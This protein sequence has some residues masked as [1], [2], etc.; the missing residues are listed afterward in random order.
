MHLLLV[1]LPRKTYHSFEVLSL[2][3]LAH[4][5]VLL[6]LFDYLPPYTQ[7]LNSSFFSSAQYPHS[8]LIFIFEPGLALGRGE[9]SLSLDEGT[10]QFRAVEVHQEPFTLGPL[11]ILLVFAFVAFPVSF[12]LTKCFCAR[13]VGSNPS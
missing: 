5:V 2:H 9:H 11:I 10:S 8:S 6:M 7:F 3:L 12:S 4:G 1:S 13:I